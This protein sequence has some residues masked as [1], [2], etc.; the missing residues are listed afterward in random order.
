MYSAISTLDNKYLNKNSA[1]SVEEQTVYGL[2]YFD[3]SNTRSAPI[4]TR[5]STHAIDMYTDYVDISQ[6][7]YSSSDDAPRVNFRDTNA[8]TLGHI[9]AITSSSSR[10]MRMIAQYRDASDTYKSGSYLELHVN[11]IPPASGSGNPTYEHYATADYR[12]ANLSN[13]D[14]ITKG[15][16]QAYPFVISG[17]TIANVAVQISDGTYAKLV[18]LYDTSVIS[19]NWLNNGAVF[20]ISYF[21][22]VDKNKT[23]EAVFRVSY[24]TNGSGQVTQVWADFLYGDSEFFAN[25][26][27]VQYKTSCVEIWAHF[28]ESW[29]YQYFTLDYLYNTGR[30]SGVYRWNNFDGIRFIGTSQSTSPS[31]YTEVSITPLIVPCNTKDVLLDRLSKLKRGDRFVG[32]GIADSSGGIYAFDLL[33]MNDASSSDDVVLY[34]TYHYMTGSTNRYYNTHTATYRVSGSIHTLLADYMSTISGSPNSVSIN[35]DS[36]SSLI[37]IYIIRNH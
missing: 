27:S 14:I 30:N 31:G 35:L 23:T 21:V 10:V 6:N 17:T 18:S 26:I 33:A 22:N 11:E 9:G 32:S 19:A 2:T 24:T 37:E 29:A 34:G 15:N 7:T 4:R 36:V 5:A 8:V 12:T 20:R 1:G 28:T 3:A 13:N 16:L 25:K